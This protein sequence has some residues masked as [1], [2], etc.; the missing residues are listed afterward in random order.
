MLLLFLT[1]PNVKCRANIT[2]PHT[3]GY[4]YSEKV[5]DKLLIIPYYSFIRNFTEFPETET[6]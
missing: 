3:R 4:F 2:P 6:E 1:Y 5:L